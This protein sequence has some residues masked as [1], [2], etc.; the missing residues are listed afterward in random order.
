[1]DITELQC[2][3]CYAPLEATKQHSKIVV[4]RFCGTENVLSDDI[5]RVVADDSHRFRVELT[6][7]IQFHFGSLDELRQLTYTL[8]GEL[9]GHRLE[10][11]NI[12]GSTVSIKS[13]E[14]V[15]WCF[16]RRLLQELVDV[17]LELRPRMEI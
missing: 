2:R 5:R 17:C 9:D 1:M 10:Y 13:I 8:D 7:A 4:C 6:K 16:R 11:D 3:S 15:E 12:R 14:L